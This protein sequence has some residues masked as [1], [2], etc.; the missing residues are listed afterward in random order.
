MEATLADRLDAALPQTQCTR[1]GHDGC[2]PY[3]EAM[4][5]GAADVNRCPPGGPETIAVLAR[6]TGREARALDP[7]CG[8]H[9]PLALARIDEARC[10]G[11]TLC[12][13]ACPVD[14]IIGARLRMHV[15][16]AALCSGC[17]LCV[18]PCPVDCIEMVPSARPWTRADALGARRRHDARAVRLAR[19]ERL[20]ER[21]VP[22]AHDAA[23]A[24]SARVAAAVERA[25]QR[26]GDAP[27]PG[28]R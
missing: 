19:G 3:A 10:I 21:A 17:E 20:D 14:A 25:R 11:C 9:A 7:A 28:A 27:R 2:R 8:A 12:I 4:A 26:R 15:V 24:R 6:A 5:A 13:D 22:A 23:A 18:A 1:C 16:V